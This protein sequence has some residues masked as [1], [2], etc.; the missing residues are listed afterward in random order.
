MASGELKTSCNEIETQ[1][2]IRL[3]PHARIEAWR[4]AIERHVEGVR[5][6]PVGRPDGRLC[7]AELAFPHASRA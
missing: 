7:S 1:G 4:I 3:P 5:T 6:A 2:K